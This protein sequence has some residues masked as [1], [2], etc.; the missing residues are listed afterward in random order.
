[1]NLCIGEHQRKLSEGKCDICS[2]GHMSMEER[3]SYDRMSETEKKLANP[4]PIVFDMPQEVVLTKTP[5]IL[6]SSFM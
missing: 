5:P 2:Y 3:E 1:M 4:K 6:V